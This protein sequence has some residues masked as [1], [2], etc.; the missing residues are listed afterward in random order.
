MSPARRARLAVGLSLVATLFFTAAGVFNR[1]A[2]VDG[3]HW[4]WT[5][6]LR[7]DRGS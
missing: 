6:A 4:A 2:A 7:G 1:A 3:G 5:A